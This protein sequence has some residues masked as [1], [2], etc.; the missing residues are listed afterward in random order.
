M[1]K[2]IHSRL[3]LRMSCAAVAALALESSVKADLS[4]GPLNPGFENGSLNWNFSANGGSSVGFNNSPTNGPSAPGTNCVLQSSDGTGNAD[5]RADL[6]ALGSAT[7]GSNAVSI[8]FDYNILDP[9]S[10]GEQI[11][12]GFRSLDSGGGFQGEH[13]FYLGTPN[14]D[15]GGQGWKH[16][17]GVAIPSFT[18]INGDIRISMNL[19]GDDTWSSGPV[20]Y[21]NF[22]VTPTNFIG[23]DNGGFENGGVNWSQGGPGGAAGSVSYNN[24]PT[25]GTSAPGTNCLLETSNGSAGL[26]NGVDFR[27]HAYLLVNNSGLVTFSFDYNILNAVN[28]GNQIRVGLRFFN[29]NNNFNGELNTYIG[30]PNGDLG[31]QGWKHMSVVATVPAGS[32]VSDIRVSMNVFGDDV[33]SS[34]GVLFDNFLVIAGTN[35]VTVAN[36][37]T[38]IVNAGAN[39]YVLTY[40]GAP[41]TSYAL[42]T[43]SSLKPPVVWTP[44]LTNLTDVSGLEMF[45]NHQAGPLGF[46]RTR[47]LP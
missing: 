47:Q 44:Q 12:V 20:L 7:Q 42:E 24:S 10:F 43:T 30:A 46:W 33:W 3:W 23:P 41:N 6:F 16:F 37:F 22:S 38:G 4:L 27:S 36:K 2:K 31:A 18:A 29:S 11:R 45:T 13:N 9:V 39:N 32:A 14:G 26:G 19:F 5:L 8:D 17:H 40:L 35:T 15:T 34:G 1:I 25:N 28:S 21:D